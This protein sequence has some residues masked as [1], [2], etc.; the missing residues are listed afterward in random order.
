MLLLDNLFMAIEFIQNDTITF[1]LTAINVLHVSLWI[2]RLRAKTLEADS[3]IVTHFTTF[4][5]Y[6][7]LGMFPYEQNCH[8]NI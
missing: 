5:T 2:N 3:N 4:T 8:N 7:V 6:V 1:L